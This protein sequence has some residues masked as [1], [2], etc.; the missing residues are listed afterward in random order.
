[1]KMVW[2]K[3]RMM[4]TQVEVVIDENGEVVEADME[5]LIEG[6]PTISIS[7]SIEV[8]KHKKK[9]FVGYKRKVSKYELPEKWTR[10]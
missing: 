8:T 4:K 1:M 10:K 6:I 2:T 7:E 5:E 9:K 3:M